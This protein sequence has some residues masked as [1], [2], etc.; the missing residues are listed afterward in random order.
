MRKLIFFIPLILLLAA[1]G[2]REPEIIDTGEP[3]HIRVLV[4]HDKNRNRVFDADEEGAVDQVSVALGD[5]CP[6]GKPR[7]E[8]FI[9]QTSPEGVSLYS[10]LEPGKYCVTYL[11]AT[12]TTTR[13][14]YWVYLNSG[15][16]IDVPFGLMGN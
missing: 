15:E 7:E 11:R 5:R 6:T 16:T 10:N 3:G 9:T 4:F 8:Q 14:T 12:N 13:I 1:C 2:S